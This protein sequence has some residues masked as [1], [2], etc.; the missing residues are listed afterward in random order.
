MTIKKTIKIMLDDFNNHN[1]F[2]F[3]FYLDLH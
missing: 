3:I 1:K 2:I